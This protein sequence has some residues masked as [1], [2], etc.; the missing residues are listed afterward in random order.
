MTIAQEIVLFTWYPYSAH[1]PVA[2]K[3]YVVYGPVI[4]G[5]QVIDCRYWDGDE[6]L[7][8]DYDVL[9]WMDVSTP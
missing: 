4:A 7:E 5:E 9:Y 2:K 8:C 1:K 6:F 3:R